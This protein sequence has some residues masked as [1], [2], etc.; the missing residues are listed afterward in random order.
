MKKIQPSRKL[1]L[2]SEAIAHLTAIRLKDVAG[3]HVM[4]LVTGLSDCAVCSTIPT[5]K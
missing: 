4:P 1:V 3:G 5:V 2:T